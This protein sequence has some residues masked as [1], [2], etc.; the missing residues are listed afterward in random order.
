MSEKTDNMYGLKQ[1]ADAIGSTP[2]WITILTQKPKIETITIGKK[3]YIDIEK[4][5]IELYK[6]KI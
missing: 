6:K 2:A 4:Y 1:F 5:P 3:R